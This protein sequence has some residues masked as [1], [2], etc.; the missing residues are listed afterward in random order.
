MQQIGADVLVD[1]WVIG[2]SLPFELTSVMVGRNEIG[3]VG[4]NVGGNVGVLYRLGERRWRWMRMDRH[5]GDAWRCVGDAWRCVRDA[6]SSLR[7]A[8]NLDGK[9]SSRN[10]DRPRRGGNT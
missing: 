8:R 10:A 9:F 5:L 2:S 4:G 7:D 6:R 1:W 3:D